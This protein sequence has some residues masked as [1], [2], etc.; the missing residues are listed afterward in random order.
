MSLSRSGSSSAFSDR[1]HRSDCSLSCMAFPQRFTILIHLA[2]GLRDLREI[3]VAAEKDG[4]VQHNAAAMRAL[5]FRQS[6]AGTKT[7]RRAA[8]MRGR[9]PL[10][11]RHAFGAYSRDECRPRQPEQRLVELNA[12][13]VVRRL[14]QIGAISKWSPPRRILH[15]RAQK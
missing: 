1:A 3:G 9:K 5:R 13:L 7:P 2:N 6:A 4:M 8:D 10:V 14:S 15:R 12:L 11:Q